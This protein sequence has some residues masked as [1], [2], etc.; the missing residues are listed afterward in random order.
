MGSNEGISREISEP[1]T[2]A[3]T[4]MGICYP[5]AGRQL[6]VRHKASFCFT[7]QLDREPAKEKTT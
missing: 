7:V 1:V 3:S 2:A 4:L 5:S 6:S